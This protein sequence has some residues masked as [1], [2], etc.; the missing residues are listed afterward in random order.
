MTF[1]WYYLNLVRTRTSVVAGPGLCIPLA[2]SSVIP[3][4][5]GASLYSL[6]SVI[7]ATH[8]AFLYSLGIS[9]NLMV[10]RTT[11]I[12]NAIYKF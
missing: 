6:S 11:C 1:C 12:H 8:G 4:A 3:A 10:Y 9:E 5:H 7:P 2:L